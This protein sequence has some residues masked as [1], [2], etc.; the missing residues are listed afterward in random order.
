MPQRGDYRR[1]S[2]P[3]HLPSPTLPPGLR[4]GRRR[5]PIGASPLPPDGRAR[6]GWADG[7]GSGTKPFVP[8]PVRASRSRR[9]SRLWR[10]R[11]Q[12]DSAYTQAREIEAYL[13]GYPK[14]AQEELETLLARADASPPIERRYVYALYGQAI[15][16]AGK[17][18]EAR[19]LAER[20]EREVHTPPD[21]ALLA[22]ARL[23]RA[24]A[25][26]L[27]GDA[28]KANSLRQGGPAGLAGHVRRLPHVLGRD[29][30][31]RHGEEPGPA[32]GGAR[33]AAGRAARSPNATTTPI[34]G[35]TRSTSSPTSICS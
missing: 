3:C 30:D 15:V 29:V 6:R 34:A 2:R 11:A 21:E 14:R 24:T 8:S 18:A 35:P 33:R 19:A 31:R 25:E 10:Q 32:R 12:A 27:G 26:W 7:R 22:T 17:Y 5:R 23:V 1:A 20:L 16:A 13:Y 9:S 4:S 28:A